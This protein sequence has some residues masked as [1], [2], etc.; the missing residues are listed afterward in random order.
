MDDLRKGKW[1]KNEK[2]S[3]STG[4]LR[5]KKW[6]WR[7]VV[8]NVVDVASKKEKDEDGT[9]AMKTCFVD[10]VDLTSKKEGLLWWK[11]VN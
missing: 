6:R 4:W 8:V 1:M 10:V 3:V 7:Y 5:R 9:M 2:S 11:I